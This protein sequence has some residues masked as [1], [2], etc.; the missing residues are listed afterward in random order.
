[1]YL[2]TICTRFRGEKS[3]SLY[4][5][6]AY[7][8]TFV[9]VSGMQSERRSSY[10]FSTT[11][12]IKFGSELSKRSVTSERMSF[13]SRWDNTSGSNRTPNATSSNVLDWVASDDR[14]MTRI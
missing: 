5:I 9:G 1:M 10:I 11:A 6:V 8:M 7:I 12:D 14:S 3:S 2:S 4:K 13:R